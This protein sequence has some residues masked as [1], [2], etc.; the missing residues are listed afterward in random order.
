MKMIPASSLTDAELTVTLS[1]LARNGRQA[2]IALIVHLAEFDARSLY[3]AAGFGTLFDDCVAVLR[4]SEVVHNG[5]EAD[6]FFQP[7]RELVGGWPEAQPRGLAESQ[8]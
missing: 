4:L 6:V 3:K 1:L 7:V 5:D 8:R 2:T